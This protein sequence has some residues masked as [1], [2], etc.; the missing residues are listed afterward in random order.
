[1]IDW[2]FPLL[3]ALRDAQKPVVRDAI[4]VAAQTSDSDAAPPRAASEGVISAQQIAER[5]LQRPADVLESV[6]GVI[7]SQHSGEGKANQYYLRGFNLDHGTDLAQTV[8]GAPVN[9]PSNAHGQGYSDD[10]FVMPELID[11]VQYRKGPYYADAGDFASAGSINIDYVSVLVQPLVSLT[12]GRFGY[13][14]LFAAGSQSL[15]RGELLGAFEFA[16]DDG[17]WLRP[18][19]YRK[20]NGLLRWTAGNNSDAFSATLSAYGGRWNASDQIPQRAV[21][22]GMSRYGEI[23]P[24]DGGDSY[25][26][27]AVADWQRRRDDTLTK[28][29]AYVIAY[30][31][32]LFSNFTYFLDDPVHGDQ[33]EQQDRRVIAGGRATRQWGENLVGIELR[34]DH[35]GTLGLY[36]TDARRRLDT[37][38]SDRVD[39][40]SISAFAQT[41]TQWTA[42]LRTTAGVRADTFLAASIASPKLSVVYTPRDGTELYASAGLGF[43]SNDAR[44]TE[45][46]LVR[47][48]GAELG[49]RTRALPRLTT[50]LALWDLDIGSELVFAGDSGR[51]EPSG[52]SRRTGME[53]TN[54]LRLS[55]H[56]SLDADLAVS[57]ARF[58]NG[59]RIPGAVERVASCGLALA[60]AGRITAA[61][62]YRYFG[63]RPLIEDN[64]IRSRASETFNAESA[65]T[66]TPRLTLGVDVLNLTNARASDVDYFYTSRLAGEPR[67]GVADVHLHPLEPRA[68]RLR[69]DARF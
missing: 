18:D 11:S 4:V 43:H 22:E 36:H 47:T 69:L 28:A 17:P 35:I 52:A 32:D 7:V 57:R 29:S 3:L 25:R 67:G 48:R 27:S 10:N 40:T 56:L 44:D 33:F 59:D 60:N 62:R 50:T 68:L 6:P 5:P 24:T 54:L 13:R 63:P 16:H 23:D 58:R 37:V 15:G 61:L 30:G 31:L 8:A 21:A 26:V 41:T 65:V 49:V 64:S 38:R 55:S 46:L 45:S 20:L 12:G 34:H 51:T 19:A 1:M 39:E 42:K 66:L 2:I 14:R 9:M 53:W